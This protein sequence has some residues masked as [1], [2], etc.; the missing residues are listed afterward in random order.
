MQNASSKSLKAFCHTKVY[1]HCFFN[2]FATLMQGAPFSLEL[3]GKL[4]RATTCR[5][6]RVQICSKL[7]RRIR[8]MF[9]VLRIV[10][11]LMRS[12]EKRYQLP[13]TNHIDYIPIY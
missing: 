3:A 4:F 9:S 1:Q 8:Y 10:C 11:R 7:E 12:K 13:Q 6:N 2:T 5:N